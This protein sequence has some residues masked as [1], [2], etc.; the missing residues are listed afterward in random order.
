[1]TELRHRV[2]LLLIAGFCAIGL[3]GGAAQAAD[4][5]PVAPL[6]ALAYFSWT[7][8]Y[9]GGNAGGLWV[10]RQW[11]DQ[12]PGDPLFGTDFGRYT[13]GGVLGGLQ[14]GCNYQIGGWVV[15]LQADYDWASGDA[16]NTPPVVF[17]PFALT[18]AARL[19]SLASVTGRFGH[20]WDHFLG[21][22]KAGGA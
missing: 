7:G 17:S 22:I 15:G 21:Y 3:V 9:A 2:K 18:D 14:G 5:A 1:M 13:Q 6:P 4:L 10:Y 20:A 8:C 19:K 12:I 11:S 16:H